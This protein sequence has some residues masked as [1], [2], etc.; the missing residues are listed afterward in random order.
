[1][2]GTKPDECW[3]LTFVG[4]DGGLVGAF[5]VA[6]LVVSCVGDDVVESVTFD[7]FVG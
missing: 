6:G 7:K 3:Q 4:A 2:Q 5:V 1:M